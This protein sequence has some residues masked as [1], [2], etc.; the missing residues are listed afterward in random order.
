MPAFR[1]TEP[2][3]PRFFSHRVV[4]PALA[5]LTAGALAQTPPRPPARLRQ[6]HGPAAAT[7]LHALDGKQL[8]AGA[9]LAPGRQ[10]VFQLDSPGNSTL[11]I[12]ATSFTLNPRSHAGGASGQCGLFF[13][14]PDG[15]SRYVAAL[16]SPRSLPRYPCAGVR[17]LGLFAES[18][19]HP[20]LIVI[21]SN[22]TAPGK[23]IAF[24]FLYSWSDRTKG[25]TR[26]VTDNDRLYKELDPTGTVAEVRAVLAH[27]H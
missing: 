21:F 6:L 5:L 18:D 12:V 14:Q 7:L 26:D 2:S 13:L 24:P 27:M 4:A 23:E 16:G 11:G 20:L 19:P 25:Y 9:S 3:P 1:T 8:P 10:Q 22:T 17:A 15:S